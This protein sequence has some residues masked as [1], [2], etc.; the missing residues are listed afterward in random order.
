MCCT[1]AAVLFAFSMQAVPFTPEHLVS[2]NV[3]T[4]RAHRASPE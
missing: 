2:T 3:N 1:I 4:R